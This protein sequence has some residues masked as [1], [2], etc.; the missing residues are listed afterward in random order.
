MFTVS[1]CGQTIKNTFHQKRVSKGSE[2]LICDSGERG[3]ILSFDTN[4]L[5]DGWINL[6][7]RA[8]RGHRAYGRWSLQRNFLEI[9]NALNITINLNKVLGERKFVSYN[10]CYNFSAT[11]GPNAA[12]I[13]QIADLYAEVLGV[14][15]QSR[16]LSIKRKFFSELREY[17]KE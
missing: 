3:Q 6:N 17:R 5:Q 2:L 1:D 8:C 11:L 14:L 15:A 9:L 7:F 10:F 12:N 16:F 4:G 13:H